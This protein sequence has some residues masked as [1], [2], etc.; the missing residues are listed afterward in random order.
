MKIAILIFLFSVSCWADGICNLPADV[1]QNL[2]PRVRN[3]ATIQQG[4]QF[5][6]V[7]IRI[8][9]DESNPIQLF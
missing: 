5:T 3:C 7:T 8:P 9:N 2:W 1:L 4:A 6:D